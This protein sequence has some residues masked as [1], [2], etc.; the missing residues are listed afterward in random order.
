MKREK[1]R[2]ALLGATGSVGQKL[3]RLLHD[4][5]WFE[6]ETLAAS[7]RSAGKVY[8]EA[9]HWLEASPLPSAV[10]EARVVTV[11][12]VEGCDIVFS[13]LDGSTAGRVEP[14]LV[15][16]GT[17]VVSNA[18]SLRMDP[19][20]PLVI[21]EVN[22][23]HLELIRG[24]TGGCVVT[25]PNCATVGLVLALKPLVDT[26]GVEAVT[27]TT[28]QAVSGAGYPGVPAMDILSNVIPHIEGEAEKLEE[29]PPKILGCLQAGAIEELP[30]KISAQV[31][32]VPVIEGHLLSVS[33]KLRNPA[34]AEEALRAFEDFRSPLEG[35]GLPSA[36]DR[37]VVVLRGRADPQ[38]RL[39]SG[40]GQGMSVSIGQVRICPV[41]D[42]RFVA[43]VHNTLRGAAGAAVL[44]AEL[45]VAKGLVSRSCG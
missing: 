13:A 16:S 35:L 6:I 28:L 18:S 23:D 36:P 11:D 26:F 5:P 31:T 41:L 29:E 4:H 2:V 37:P 25:N 1:L 21:P 24:R 9:V 42:L 27:V 34:S 12:Q 22:P 19:A 3:V 10:A 38:P 45:L 30:L 43:L 20:V 7:D 44:N 39:H 15:A 33:V 40:L 32:R 14:A 8:H 17:I